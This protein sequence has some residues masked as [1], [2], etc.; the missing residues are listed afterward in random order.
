MQLDVNA[1]RQ[2]PSTYFLTRTSMYTC[3]AV[4]ALP[5]L[6]YLLKKH[7]RQNQWHVTTYVSFVAAYLLLEVI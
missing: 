3:I 5:L 1:L 2:P 7:T 6:P 4:R